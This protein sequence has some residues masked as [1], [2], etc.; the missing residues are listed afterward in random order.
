MFVDL[1]QRAICPPDQLVHL[2]SFAEHFARMCWHIW[3]F[4]QMN[5]QWYDDSTSDL[6]QNLSKMIRAI[7]DMSWSSPVHKL[8]CTTHMR[9]LHQALLFGNHH[10]SRYKQYSCFARFGGCAREAERKTCRHEPAIPRIL[11]STRWSK[12]IGDWHESQ[13]WEYITLVLAP[14]MIICCNVLDS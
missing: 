14:D 4:N 6:T 9:H 7:S 11:L 1:A 8:H 10:R 5:S 2:N 13:T 12:S 3:D